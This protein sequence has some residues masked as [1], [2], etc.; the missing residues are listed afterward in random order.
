MQYAYNGVPENSNLY[1]KAGLP[2]TPF[3][4][5]DG[6]FIFE[7]DD[8]AKA[9]AQKARY[10]RY[11]DPNY[12]ILQVA[13][14]YRNGV[15]IQRNKPIPV[16][17]HANKGV[18][19][20]VTLGDVTKTATANDLQQWAVTFPALKATT[21]SITLKVQASHNRSRTVQQYPRR[22]RLVSNRINTSNIRVALQPTR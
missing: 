17:G 12:P 10:A 21:K 11:T 22:R 4:Q 3:A 18:K 8:A 15:I 6:K 14:Y 13:E 5:I 1:N 20:T 7:E 2:A 16:W 19:V 9:A